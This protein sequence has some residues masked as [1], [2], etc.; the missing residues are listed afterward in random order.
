[1][2][3]LF[4]VGKCLS[5]SCKKSCAI[6]VL[7][8]LLNG[9]LYQVTFRCLFRLKLLCLEFALVVG[10]SY[11]S[12]VSKLLRFKASLYKGA[13]VSNVSLLQDNALMRLLIERGKCRITEGGWLDRRL[14]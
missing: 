9:G 1:M 8:F 10:G 7:T 11:V 5:M 2:L 12:C 14:M 3:S 6:F 13:A 4:E